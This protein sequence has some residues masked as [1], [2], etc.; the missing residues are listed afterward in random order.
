[1]AIFK[2]QNI[3]RKQILPR[4]FFPRPEKNRFL[5]NQD[6]MA[7]RNYFDRHRPRNLSYLLGK[8]YKWMNKYL[9]NKTRI[10]ELGCGPGFGSYF[11]EKQVVFTDIEKHPW[12][13]EKV[14]ALNLPYEDD[15]V[16][17]FICQNILHHVAHPKKLLEDMQRKL[18][19]G[20]CVL[21]QEPEL[22]IS[23]KLLLMA[24]R[25]EGWSDEVDVFDDDQMCNDPEDPWSANNGI[26]TYLFRDEK[27]F[28]EKSLKRL[29][30]L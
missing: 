7:A 19:K 3:V 4:T 21:I 8:R 17:A 15:S 24:T 23:F 22:S 10:I 11:Y 27:I 6:A 2:G 28:Q 12:V 9:E 14:D 26:A 18:K 5:H 1:M 20:G 29:P 30:Q 13:D 25:H 16:D